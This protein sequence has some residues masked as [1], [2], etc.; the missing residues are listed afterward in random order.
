MEGIPAIALWS[1]IKQVF[2]KRSPPKGK[3]QG[4]ATPSLAET[5]ASAPDGSRSNTPLSIGTMARDSRMAQSTVSHEMSI[6]YVPPSM[7][8][9][10]DNV[11]LTIMEDNEAVI[12]MCL[13]GRSPA[14]R[15]VG[16]THRVDLDHTHTFASVGPNPR[17]PGPA[18]SSSFRA[19]DRASGPGPRC[20]PTE[21]QGQEEEAET[22]K[23]CNP[24]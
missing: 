16:R 6:D 18:S 4:L 3:P 15:H 24:G 20:C 1:L 9:F 22:Q 10:V 14:L 12:K 13:K 11:I 8:P 21:R 19:G 17:S 7:P 2:A 23:G 5:Q